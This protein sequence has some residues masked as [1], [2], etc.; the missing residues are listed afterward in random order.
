MRTSLFVTCA[1]LA[2]GALVAAGSERPAQKGPPTSSKVTYQCRH[3]DPGSVKI[4]GR[5]DEP[6][7][8]RAKPMT[9]FGV[10]RTEGKV[11]TLKTEARL[12]WD[13]KYL[14]AAFTCT[15]DGI[16]SAATER[17]QP[18]W[19]GEAAE[20]FVCPRGLDAVYY[21]FNFSPNNVISDSG[22]ETWKY[23]EH[24]KNCQKGARGF[25]ADLRSA[26]R[27]HRDKGG[28]VTGWSVEA[29]IPFK[30]FDVAGGK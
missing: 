22:V 13:D 3:V 27:V 16:R 2:V 26:T 24:V 15:N 11:A 30:H 25:N 28:A 4:D 29:A 12:L 10:V 8:Q 5:P 17:D 21:E 9:D 19:Q 23:E 18:V 6:A 20:L 14:Y 7:W 1:A